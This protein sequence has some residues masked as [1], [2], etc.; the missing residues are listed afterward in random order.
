MLVQIRYS[1]NDKSVFQSIVTSRH[2]DSHQLSQ[3]SADSALALH[4]LELCRQHFLEGEHEINQD[5][6]RPRTIS[7]SSQ[8]IEQANSK[9]TWG[10]KYEEIHMAIGGIGTR[11]NRRFCLHF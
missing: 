2:G 3:R 7:R 11:K 6:H 8:P 4:P 5:T 1:C 9:Q 10:R